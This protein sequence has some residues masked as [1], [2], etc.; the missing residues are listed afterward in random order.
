MIRYTIQVCRTLEYLHSQPRPVVHQD[1]KPANLILESHLGDVRLVDF[2]T[3]RTHIPKGAGPGHGDPT[4]VF[5]TDGYAPPEQYRG[6]PVPR[7]DVFSLAATAYH[8][9]TTDDPREHPFKWPRLKALPRELALALQRALRTDPEKRSTARELRQALEALATPQRTLESFTF[10]G[11]AQIRSVGALPAHC[12][13]HWDAARSFLYNGD[14]QRWLRDINRHDLVVAADQVVERYANHDSGL[15]AFLRLVDP[16][17][18]RPKITGDPPSLDLGAIARESAIIRQVSLLNTSRGYTQAKVGASE[19][20][21]EVRPRTLHLWAGRPVD[22]HVHI[23]AE[24][25]PFRSRQRGLVA[26]EPEGHDPVRIPVTAQVSLFREGWRI[27]RRAVGAAVPESWRM[28]RAAWH[29]IVRIWG[30]FRR[31]FVAHPWL[32][33]I[34]WVVLGTAIGAGLYYLPPWAQ[35]LLVAGWPLQRPERWADYVPWVVLGAPLLLA[36][37]WLAFATLTL[38]GSLVV[39]ALRGAWNSFFR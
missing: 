14:F 7:S 27:L 9:L 37:L 22:L 3:A 21:I 15:E 6:N 24:G 32:V 31:P 38:V 19:P 29:L 35:G 17:L 8:L 18:P 12:D 11:G 28:C 30:A 16:G 36:A 39:G 10:P 2:G 4:S 33:W 34:L 1:L 13:E 25:L 5:G 20:W 26:V 23:H